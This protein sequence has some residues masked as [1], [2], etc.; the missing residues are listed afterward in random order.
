MAELRIVRLDGDGLARLQH[1][2]VAAEM[3]AAV[4]RVEGPAAVACVQGIVTNDVQKRGPNRAC[5]GA[6][7]TPK[8]MIITDGW[9]LRDGDAIVMVLPTAA[10]TPAMELFKRQLPPRL[11]KVHDLGATHCVVAVVGAAA[12]GVAES[13]GA[14]SSAGQL[15][16]DAAASGRRL[17][18]SAPEPAP[19][20]ALFVLPRDAA[21]ALLAA[22]HAQGAVIGTGADLDA[23]RILAGFP[24]LGAEIDE[25]TLPQEVRFDEHAGVSYDKGCY[26]GQETVARIHF[27]GH[28]NRELRAMRVTAGPTADRTAVEI[29][30]EGRSVGTARSLLETPA[31]SVALAPVRR[32][33]PIGASVETLGVSAVVAEP[34]THLG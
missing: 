9:F 27:R 18:V 11:A 16:G 33:V 2:A 5:Y 7:L 12:R 3:D 4:F 8:G 17:A 6:L 15:I 14:P 24:A 29:M 25:K 26:T 1:G 31:G 28:P 10:H 23:A 13:A 22:L 20:G 19:F 32:E 30:H 34:P 21:P